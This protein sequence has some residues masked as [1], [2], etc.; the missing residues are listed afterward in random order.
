MPELNFNALLTE[1]PRSVAQGYLQGQ[2]LLAQRTAQDQQRKIVDLQLQNAL[3]EQRTAG[4]EDAAY[5]AAA[6]NPTNLP[7]E[8]M[9]RGLGKQSFEANKQIIEQRKLQLEN[10]KNMVELMKTA[11]TQVMT[12]PQ[13]AEQIFSSFGQRYGI[14]VTDDIAEIR[15][16]GNN[17]DAIRQHAA[18]I[19]MEA[20]KLLP[21]F[22]TM[23]LGGGVMRQGYNPV[24]GAPVSHGTFIPEMPLPA[25]VEAQKLRIAGAGAARTTVDLGP[26]KKYNERFGTLV[27]DQDMEKRTIAEK[28]PEVAA[29]ADRILDI[30]DEG[31]VNTG[32][33]ADV[34]LQIGKAF[35]LIGLNDA[36]SIKNTEM[37]FSAM[38]NT[39]LGTIK[40]SGLGT[41][42][43][44]TDKDFVILQKAK[45]GQLTYDAKSIADLARISRQVAEKSAEVWNK[46]VK[47]IPVSALE[48]TGIT[49]DPIVVPKRKGSQTDDALKAQAIQDLKDGKGT[50]EQFDETFG[51]GEAARALRPREGRW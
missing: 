10:N 30:L 22:E 28:A 25:D 26:E 36:D 45:S 39:T 23:N 3:R 1:G 18:S 15:R 24:T 9:Q 38:A 29:N 37:L 13:N 42:Q 48:G 31:N 8:L 21:K 20:D 41:G 6:G 2:N 47:Q 35:N 40:S 46:R 17:P 44:F 14:D 51:P 11:A 5:K 32:T 34:R 33:L 12:N 7:S 19:A 43:G 4:E 16:L 49:T 50:P 27:A